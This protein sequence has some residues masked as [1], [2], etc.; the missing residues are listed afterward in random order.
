MLKFLNSSQ[1]D[2]VDAF[3][4]VA[5]ER[6]AEIVMLKK[7]RDMLRAELTDLHRQMDAE[8][9]KRRALEKR[10]DALERAQK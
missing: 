2:A 5:A 4:M 1:K 8:I 6:S 7:E 9:T 10:L 3:A